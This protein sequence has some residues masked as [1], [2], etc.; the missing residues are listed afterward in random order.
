MNDKKRPTGDYGQQHGR[1]LKRSNPAVVSVLTNDLSVVR[2]LR[3]S[4]L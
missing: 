1:D 2:I 4:S 3:E